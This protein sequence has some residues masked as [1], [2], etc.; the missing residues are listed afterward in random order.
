MAKFHSKSPLL[1][2]IIQ[3]DF[4]SKISTKENFN[5]SYLIHKDVIS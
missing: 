3:T 2:F 4:S 1:L 5:A